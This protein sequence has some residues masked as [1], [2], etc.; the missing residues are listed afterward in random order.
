MSNLDEEGFLLLDDEGNILADVVSIVKKLSKVPKEGYI[1]RLMICTDWR[2]LMLKACDRLDNLRS[3]MVPG[4]SFA[5]QKRQIAETKD[6]YYPII[7][8]LLDLV[9]KEYAAG[10]NKI[11]DEIIM[12]VRECEIKMVLSELEDSQISKTVTEVV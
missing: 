10:A 4:T 6:K 1:E 12:T 5:F 11:R 7:A 8:N 3:L 9:P 2:V